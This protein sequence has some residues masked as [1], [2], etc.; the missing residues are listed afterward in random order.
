MNM[1]EFVF[2]EELGEEEMMRVRRY[3]DRDMT[4]FAFKEAFRLSVSQFE[5][6][7]GEIG[8]RLTSPTN[9]SHAL[10]AEEKILSSLHWMGTGSQYHSVS[11]MHGISKSSVCRN[12]HEVISAIVSVLF[13]RLVCW[14][15]DV[16]Q[17]AAGFLQKGGFP[18]VAGCV[19]GTMVNIDAPTQFEEQYVNRHGKHA[20]NVMAICGPGL[21]LYAINASWP[22]SIHDSRVLW[23]TAIFRKFDVENWRPFPD[24]VIL[25]DSAYPLKEWLIP[26]VIRNPENPEEQAFLRAHRQTRR[27]I[28]NCFGIMK[29]KFPCLNHMRLEPEFAGMIVLA[30]ATL[31]NIALSIDRDDYGVEIVDLQGGIEDDLDNLDDPED[32]EDEPEARGARAR[33]ER[34]LTRLINFFR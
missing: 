12:V 22:G 6:L 17:I 21:M 33:G 13:Q 8:V 24:A 27:L 26:P 28:E 5:F 32:L 7:H 23:N 34:R 14:P 11:S 30:C 31:H 20:I 25:G 16:G 19:D 3:F 9:R 15:D 1:Y 18:S 2:G 29:E 10:T 4:D